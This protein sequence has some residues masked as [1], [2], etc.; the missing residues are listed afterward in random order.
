MARK[1]LRHPFATC[2][3]PKHFEEAEQE[4]CFTTGKKER[5]D[6]V[7]G[8]MCAQINSRITDGCSDEPVKPAAA[9]VKQCAKNSNHTVGRYGSRRKR[10]SGS[11]AIGRIGK[12]NSRFLKQSQERRRSEEHTSALQ[13]R[14]G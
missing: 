8:P 4:Q 10:W 12:P 5:R 9:S 3:P 1:D 2:A 7:A 6:D 14:F 11:V 13:S